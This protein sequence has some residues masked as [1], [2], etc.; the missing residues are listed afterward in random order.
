MFLAAFGNLSARPFS[1]EPSYDKE[2]LLNDSIFVFRDK[3]DLS[4]SEIRSGKYDSQ[5]LQG[6]DFSLDGDDAEIF[7]I[8]FTALNAG[9][10]DADAVLFFRDYTGEIGTWDWINVFQKQN[11]DWIRSQTGK[12]LILS[13]RIY[14]DGYS[15]VPITLQASQPSEFYIRLQRKVPS[16]AAPAK[17]ELYIQSEISYLKD[18]QD[19][20]YL[21]GIFL[22]AMAVMFLYNLFLYL[23]L[24][25]RSYLYYCFYILSFIL[26]W[27]SYYSYGFY[28]L[29]SES[30]VWNHHSTLIF[31]VLSAVSG[32]IF[33]LHF[34]NL[35]EF[36]KN[37]FYTVNGF[38]IA[39][40]LTVIPGFFGAWYITEQ[41]IALLSLAI[42]FVVLLS[43]VQVWRKGYRPALFFTMAY[44]FLC[45]AIILFTL[46]Y[47]GL[48]G[49]NFIVVNGMQIAS[50]LETILLSLGLAD[51]I[52][53]MRMEKEKATRQAIINLQKAD[54]LKDEFLATTS[55][56]LRTPLNGIVGI[57]E[58][59]I[60]GS[61]GILNEKAEE[62]L[63][64]VSSS[65]RRLSALIND[66]LDVSRLKKGEIN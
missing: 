31:T 25:D 50:L 62:N 36:S 51:R 7:W 37:F 33:A 47:L 42:S 15:A 39:S 4:F 6:K 11:G 43:A 20:G 8:R 10:E 44:A 30:P 9:A 59:M 54:R 22:G 29:W 52:N 3:K 49:R 34:L 64:L 1:F 57:A 63:K 48:F 24:R 61:C 21:H 13:E 53:L 66:I 45:L 12:N 19:A 65:G 17:L 35:K 18:L 5:F 27:G 60:D 28:Y 16:Y 41:L 56:E 23:S 40:A 26:L 2:I 32:S 38:W 14:R 58:S 46:H 55:H